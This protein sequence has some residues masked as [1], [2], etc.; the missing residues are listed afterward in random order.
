MI[1]PTAKKPVVHLIDGN[2]WVN[3]AFYATPVLHTD[4]GIPTNAIK[5]FH[6]MLLSL[7]NKILKADQVPYIAVCFD[8]KRKDTFRADVFKK[9]QKR[10]PELVQALLPASSSK[11]YKGNRNKGK[12]THE[13]EDLY[14]QIRICREMVEWAGFPTFDGYSI[15]QPVEAD[16][17][18]GTLAKL[19]GCLK[20]IQ[21]RDKDFNQ[22]IEPGVRVYHPPQANSEAKLLTVKNLYAQ[23]GL[24]PDQFIEY[25]MLFGDTSD[26][27]PGVP[28][29]GEK[30]ATALL[31]RWGTIENIQEKAERVQGR[32][33]KVALTIAGLPVEPTAK[34]KKEG[35]KPA[36]APCPDFEVTRELATIRTD[37]KNLPKSYKELVMR[38][39]KLKKLKKLKKQLEFKELFWV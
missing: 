39:P 17:I 31:N 27:I 26:N 10:D 29:C 7:H 1:F 4:D 8:I 33:R 20:L 12:S 38:E 22:C 14:E 19:K 32:E 21:T 5:A 11:E 16:D 2:N 36:V 15:D 6:N 30:T 3:R 25:L 18:I 28:G 34:A 23:T 37:V 24:R 35:A 13:I 9:W